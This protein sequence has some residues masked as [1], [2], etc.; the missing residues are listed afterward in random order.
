VL[1]RFHSVRVRE[2]PERMPARSAAAKE[3]HYMR[4]I[5]D[6]DVS[7]RCSWI[8]TVPPP[9]YSG[10]WSCRSATTG[11][12]W[13]R[14][15]PA[16]R[17]LRLYREDPVQIVPP[18]PSKSCALLRGRYTEPGIELP[19]VPLSQK[20][21]GALYS[22]DPRQPELLRQPPLGVPKLRSDRPRACGEYA[23]IIC[24][25][26]SFMVRPICVRRC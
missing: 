22:G 14:C 18:R 8:V 1:P 25:P 19:N 10:I 2:V 13:P 7:S 4:A 24:A 21:I 20:H 26:N 16:H 23:A 9:T 3:P 17:S 11:P 5:A 12:G 6:R 15:C